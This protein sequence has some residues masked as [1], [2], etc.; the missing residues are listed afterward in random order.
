M[1]ALVSFWYFSVNSSNNPII[2]EVSSTESSQEVLGEEVLMQTE[3][4]AVEQE[5]ADVV[6]ILEKIDMSSW[7]SYQNTWYGIFLKY[8]NDWKEPIV[9][10]TIAGVDWEQQIQFR[11]KQTNEENP[12][13]GFDVVVYNVA[14]VKQ[15]SDTEEYPKL[16]NEELNNDQN[17]VTIEGHLLETG[18]YTAEEIYVPINDDCYNSSLFFSNTRDKYIYNLVPKLKEGI[19]LSGDPSDEIVNHMPDF[20]GVASTLQLVDIVR[21]KPA[22]ALA[23]KITAPKPVSYKIEGGKMV[24]AKKKDHP[25]KSDKKKGKHLDMECCLDPD[26]YPNPW[27]YYPPSKYGK[28]LK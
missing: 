20:F 22:P 14:K 13:E 16:K 12:F 3:E 27:C 6:S 23:P 25:S 28:Y 19:G 2:K 5:K 11:F 4:D 9:R 10:K 24:C 7:V 21:P 8:P 26:E 17:C 15:L 18:D 1:L